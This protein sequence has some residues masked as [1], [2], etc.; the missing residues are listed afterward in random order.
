MRAAPATEGLE[1][2][3]PPYHSLEFSS[4][5]DSFSQKTECKLAPMF[6]LWPGI[7]GVR[8]RQ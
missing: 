7:D 4:Q 2:L 3:F 5:F 8:E 1:V 6:Q